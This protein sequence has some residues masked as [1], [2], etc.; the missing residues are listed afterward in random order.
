VQANR[1]T[2]NDTSQ[3]QNRIRQQQQNQNTGQ[4]RN[5]AFGNGAFGTRNQ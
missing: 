4:N 1:N 5:S 3:L 2:Q